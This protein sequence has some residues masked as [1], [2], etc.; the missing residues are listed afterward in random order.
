MD[1][2][3]RFMWMALDL[4]RQGRGLTNPNPMVGAVVVKNGEVVGTGYHQVAGGPHAEYIALQKAGEK[5]RDATLYA[6]LEP[7]CHQGKTP[8]CAEN[9]LK[10][11]IKKV[12]VAMEDPNPLVDG[13]GISYLREKGIKV[14]VGILE[15]KARHLNEIFIK[16]IT[17]RKPF[18]IVKT[19]M[20][21]DGKIATREGDSR[22]ITGEKSRQ[23]VH[24]LR[25]RADA[26][27]VGIETV[28][29]DNPAL[30]TR[31]ADDKDSKDAIRVILD[32]KA[33]LPHDAKVIN[34]A[35]RASTIVAVTEDA[36]PERCGALRNLGVEVLTLPSSGGRV[37]AEALVEALGKRK[38]SCLLVEGGGT[39]NYSLLEKNLVDKLYLF[40]APVIFG[41]KNAPTPFGGEGIDV[42][43]KAWA[44]SNFELKQYGEDLLIIGY[45][46]KRDEK[47]RETDVYG[48]SGG[49]GISKVV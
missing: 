32:S 24:R 34:P 3:E 25:S 10:A 5:A 41:G 27:V 1:A 30:T 31:I 40:L 23:L 16:Y 43:D 37:S 45:P 20:S 17:T 42:L 39:V 18:V 49:D 6:N 9:I 26:V 36:P 28:I 8:P 19:A 11:G 29:H 21:F 13:K 4:A 46:V 35:S 12:V 38:I 44:V 47:E 22:W 7:C 15:D 33:R 2:D 14:K 48:N